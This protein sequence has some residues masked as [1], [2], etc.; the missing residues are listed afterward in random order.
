M[1][2]NPINIA[3]VY[4][5][6]DTQKYAEYQV[7]QGTTILQALQD[8]GWLAMPELAEFGQ[9]CQDNQH[10]D[11]NHRAWYVGVYSVKKRLDESLK[12]GDRIE[13]YR[14]LSADPMSQR[15]AK[16]K[17]KAKQKAAERSHKRKRTA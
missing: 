14:S 9:W 4:A 2:V 5:G 16:S 10:S 12:D 8:G 15:Q 1:A 7:E 11:P 6:Q 17:L 13:I 3:V